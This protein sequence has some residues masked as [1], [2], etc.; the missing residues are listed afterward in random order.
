MLVPSHLILSG[1]RRELTALYPGTLPEGSSPLALISAAR[2]LEARERGGVPFI[3]SRLDTLNALL[4]QLASL[5]LRVPNWANDVSA[6]QARVAQAKQHTCLQDLEEAHKQVLTDTERLLARLIASPALSSEEHSK[7]VAIVSAWESA[8]RR[9]I[10]PI[11]KD[12]A[13]VDTTITQEKMERY[14]QQ[15]FN[16]PTLKVTRFQ[17]LPGGYGKQTILMDVSGKALDGPLVLRRDPGEPPV[18]NDCHRIHNEYR[19]IRAVFERGFPAPEALWLDTEHE[20]LPGGDFIVM[21]RAPGET[22]GNVFRSKD[23]IS[24]QL[25]QVL[26]EAMARL[27]TMPPCLELGDLTQSIRTDAWSLSIPESITRYLQEWLHIYQTNT[28]NPSLTLMGLY[29]WLLAN[30]PQ[31]E[32]R[33]ALLHGDIGFHNMVVHEGR[34]SVLLDWEFAH[35]GDPAEDLGYV[36]NVIHGPDWDTFMQLYRAAGGPEVDPV[37]LHYFQVW[38]HVRNASASNLAMG[39]LADGR[40]NE[41]KLLHTGHYHFPLFIQAA[42]DLIAAGPYGETKAVDY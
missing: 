9:A 14:L 41:L 15:R 27:H 19:I 34:L 20:L 38:A 22:G 4:A 40:Q 21:R 7:L 24:R 35:V 17:P 8:D 28:H 12:E 1:M 18:D 23:S 3:Q 2:V 11:P 36:R 39:T 16:E 10:A 33:P 25:L 31:A 29:G 6:L 42:C 32:G 5:P 30:V 37:R 13:Q 26:A